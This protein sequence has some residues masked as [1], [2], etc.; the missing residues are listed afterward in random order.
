MLRRFFPQIAPLTKSRTVTRE[1]TE[2]FHVAEIAGEFVRQ[3]SNMPRRRY[4]LAIWVGLF[5]C[6]QLFT[7]QARAQVTTAQYNNARTGANIR[8]TILTPR[9]VNSKRFGKLFSIRV[10]G[11]VF[12]QPLYLPQLS[13]PGKGIH[14]VVFIV[15][16]HDSVY[17]FD[18]DHFS[19]KP[20]WHTSFLHPECGVTTVPSDD[21]QCPLLGSE[22]GV[23]STPA[24]DANTGTLY[25]IART[26][27]KDN[28]GHVRYVQK[29]HALDV[30][31]GKEKPNGPIGIRAS[32]DGQSQGQAAR[33]DFD[34]LRNNQRSA[35]LLAN[36][37]LYIAWAS[38]CDVG[39]YHG[40]VMVYNAATLKQVGVF[41][42]SPD[43]ERSGIWQ[44][45]KGIAADAAGNIFFTTGNGI[46]D[47]FK[48]GRNY[49]DSVLKMKLTKAGL[50]VRD[51]FTPFNH[52]KLYEIDL[53]LGSEGPILLPD[54]PG[55]HPHLL[56]VAGKG[57][58][59]YLI[60][61]DK[62][63]NFHAGDDSHAVQTIHVAE[64]GA[65][66]SAAYWN[67][68]LYYV[69]NEDYLKDFAVKGGQLSEKPV[70]Q[71]TTKFHYPG[72]TPTV[73]SAGATNGI[74]W[75]VASRGWEID[76][77]PAVLHAFD[78]SNVAHELYN[79]EQNSSRDRAGIAV[80]F[81]TPVVA[82]GRVYMGTANGVEVYGALPSR[83]A[84][85]IVAPP[86]APIGARAE[87]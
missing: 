57:G 45:E 84:R 76:P 5:A 41:N 11:A 43:T 55:A 47:V 64:G 39:S 33:V 20:L 30:T 68:H 77:R 74:V 86:R 36:G 28:A 9:N 25:L 85:L 48:G 10:D 32:V 4:A 60:D 18:A 2:R 70:A 83:S 72:A 17:A 15:T 81:T 35:L 65:F 51:Y 69:F 37:K 40:W 50:T 87:P 34:P 82:N 66:G 22:I 38:S 24:I 7:P 6:L 78:A 53:D 62:M 31:T 23:T 16:E 3:F 56:T 49:G 71:A 14:N 8:E 58:T 27:E 44:G 29:L 19:A 59:L 80:R 63:G 67:Q 26:K 52:D 79:S 54:Q 61:R 42:A 12:A 46:F 75:V 21:V 13:I 73:S 1:R